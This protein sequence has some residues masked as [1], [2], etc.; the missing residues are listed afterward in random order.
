MAGMAQ[1]LILSPQVRGLHKASLTLS[2]PGRAER[3]ASCKSL[4]S[5][6]SLGLN[7]GKAECGAELGSLSWAPVSTEQR[8][9]G[10]APGLGAQVRLPPPSRPTE[11]GPQRPLLSQSQDSLLTERDILELS[12]ERD[13]LDFSLPGSPPIPTQ[14]RALSFPR[15]PCLCCRRHHTSVITSETWPPQHESPC[16]PPTTYLVVLLG[17]QLSDPQEGCILHPVSRSAEGMLLLHRLYGGGWRGQP[18][19]LSCQDTPHRSRTVP[20]THCSAP[21]V[22]EFINDNVQG[23]LQGETRSIKE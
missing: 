7:L 14:G 23:I 1:A 19:S 5:L 9:Q 11:I 6:G 13:T 21:D 10:W 3:K 22:T 8:A 2:P 18:I 20:I 4:P 17:P 16:A 15:N 12:T